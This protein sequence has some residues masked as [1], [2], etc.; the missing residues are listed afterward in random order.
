MLCFS[1]IQMNGLRDNVSFLT[2]FRHF[3]WNEERK[4]FLVERLPPFSRGYANSFTISPLCQII[5]LCSFTLVIKSIKTI[6]WN[7]LLR[8]FIVFGPDG[9]MFYLVWWPLLIGPSLDCSNY[10]LMWNEIGTINFTRLLF[11]NLSS[12][13]SVFMSRGWNGNV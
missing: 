7:D 2:C 5:L 9:K 12:F 1:L 10:N 3:C 13:G 8:L 4:G 6:N 11:N